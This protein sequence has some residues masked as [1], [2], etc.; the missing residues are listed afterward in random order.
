MCSSRPGCKWDAD[1]RHA[2]QNCFTFHKLCAQIYLGNEPFLI[3]PRSLTPPMADSHL[4]KHL[5]VFA[6][7]AKTDAWLFLQS[8]EPSLVLLSLTRFC[9]CPLQILF[10]CYNVF[11]FLHC[12]TLHPATRSETARERMAGGGHAELWPGGGV[13]GLTGSGGPPVV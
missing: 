8:L 9:V 3:S 11:C 5:L 1:Y 2:P 12:R 7:G 13:C 4:Q 6:S 10:K